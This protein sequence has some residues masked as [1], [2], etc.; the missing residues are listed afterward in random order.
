MTIGMVGSSS[1]FYPRLSALSAFI[2]VYPRSFAF[3]RA[4]PACPAFYPRSSIRGQP[5][6]PCRTIAY[7]HPRAHVRLRRGGEQG[8]IPV[9]VFGRAAEDHAARAD[10]GGRGVEVAQV[11]T[12]KELGV[13][14]LTAVVQFNAVHG[15]G[16]PSGPHVH[17]AAF[18]ADGVADDLAVVG[19]SAQIVVIAVR[20]ADSAKAG[21]IRVDS[22]G[23]QI[24]LRQPRQA[25]HVQARTER[26]F[27]RKRKRREFVFGERVSIERQSVPQPPHAVRPV[28]S[29]VPAPVLVGKP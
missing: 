23:P 16:M 13:H 11:A 8:E 15:R 5:P 2:R 19:V 10:D 21:D 6:S 7:L 12:L 24:E 25:G 28:E 29:R 27:A 3:V 14:M 1:A 4:Y 9:L 22:L 20:H 18:S 26:R 17:A